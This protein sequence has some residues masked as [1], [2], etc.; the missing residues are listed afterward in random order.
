MEKRYCGWCGTEVF[1]KDETEFGIICPHC[2]NDFW[3]SETLPEDWK[4]QGY[5]LINDRLGETRCL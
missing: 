3:W 1:E 4:E 2:H 5:V